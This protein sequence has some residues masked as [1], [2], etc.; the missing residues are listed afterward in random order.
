V[1]VHDLQNEKVGATEL[2]V[3]VA[4]EEAPSAK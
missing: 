1:G 4:R 3:T 2:P